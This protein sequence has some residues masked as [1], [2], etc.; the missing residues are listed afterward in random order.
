MTKIIGLGH[1]SRTG[2]NT[3]ANMIGLELAGQAPGMKVRIISFASKLKDICNQLYSWD[4][5]RDEAF[6]ETEEGAALRDIKLQTLNMTPVEVWIAMGTPAV[7]E[8]VYQNTWIDYA[9]RGNDESDALI[10]TDVRF[11]NEVQAIR[12][13][14]WNACEVCAEW[15]GASQH[16][17]GLSPN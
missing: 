13:L 7:R 2:K 6:Y 9:L 5:L 10:I 17:S 16:C 4:G 1:Y 14:G 8:N 11:P 15:H 12:D 3:L